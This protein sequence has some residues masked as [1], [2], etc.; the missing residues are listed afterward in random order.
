M[1]RQV[2]NVDQSNFWPMFPAIV[3]AI[4]YSES[5]SFDLEM[6]GVKTRTDGWTES[7][8]QHTYQQAKAAAQ[9]FNILQVGISCAFYDEDERSYRVG[10]FNFDLTAMLRGSTEVGA[11]S[12]I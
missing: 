4:F 9:I 12:T 2:L 5:V 10:S 3:E 8:T 1:E 7:H 6:T 11:P